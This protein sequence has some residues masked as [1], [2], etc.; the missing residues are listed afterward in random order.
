MAEREGFEL[1]PV[2][3]RER[4]EVKRSGSTLAKSRVQ[5]GTE[6]AYEM[7]EREGFEPPIPVKV[8][9]LSRRLVS[10]A[11]AP[12]RATVRC[13]FSRAGVRLIALALHYNR[14]V[15]TWDVVV[16]GGGVIGLSLA[17]RLRQSGAGVLV[18]EKGEPAREATYAAGGMIAH[19]DLGN[20]PALA[21]MIAASAHMYPEFVA[22]LRAEAFESPDL[23]E[24]GTIAFFES[25]EVAACDGG[26]E[27][28]AA[29][30]AQ[31]EPLIGLRGRAYL[32]PES[33][34]DPRKLGSA[35]EKAAR[36]LGVDFVTGAAVTE[37]AVLGGR[38]T[39]VR[40]AKSFYAAGVVVN[41]AGAWAAQMKPMGVPT[42]PVKGQMV[43][44]LPPVGSPGTGPLIGH[45]VRT[46]EVYIIP[47]SDGR[48]LLGATV[49][50]LGFDKRVDPDTV[51]RLHQAAM[52]VVPKIGDM[53]IHDAW[54]GLRPGSPDGLPILGATSLKGYFAATGHYRDGI[55]LA[56]VTALVMTQLLT[57][58]RPNFDLSAFSPQRFH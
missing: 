35:L 56:P 36:T 41:C 13:H 4:S 6:R 27:L 5:R 18:V 16:I 42:R 51:Q 54:A 32:L 44:I 45:V 48:M 19:C 11:H 34:V 8:W 28:D 46:P 53:R 47:R 15:K 52:D 25:E 43:C 58:R 55:L 1:E 31:L 17:W 9:P 7:A 22:Q 30:L 39:G 40:T 49:E 37:V 29:A 14:S 38:T 12:L 33:S 20:P 10:T 24:Q 50:E 23:R 26:L 57:G 3:G 2:S 21:K